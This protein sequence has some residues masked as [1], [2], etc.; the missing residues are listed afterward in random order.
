VL[1]HAS[2]VKSHNNDQIAEIRRAI[3]DGTMAPTLKGINAL[4]AVPFQINSWLLDVMDQ[5][6]ER[7]IKVPGFT[8]ADK[9]PVPGEALCGAVGCAERRRAE[10]GQRSGIPHRRSTDSATATSRRSRSI[11]RRRT[12]W[13]NSRSSIC[14]CIWTFGAVCT[15]SRASASPGVTMCG[16]CSCSRTALRLPKRVHIGY[17]YT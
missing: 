12:G 17:K 11:W 7:G 5:V 3:A 2:L 16:R 15:R 14:R 9:V 4:Q 6:Q 13:P 1:K 8:V 10:A